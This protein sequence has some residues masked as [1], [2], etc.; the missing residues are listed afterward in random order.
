MAQA[1]NWLQIG[2]DIDGENAEDYFGGSISMSWDGLIVAIGSNTNNGN[3]VNAGHVRVYENTVGTWTQVGGDIDGE[4]AGD[5]S[6]FTVSL[7]S[8]GS[9]LAI[10]APYNDGNGTDAGHVRI[11]QNV[12]G[13]WLQVGNDIDGENSGDLF[14]HSIE[15]SSDGSIVAI[16]APCNSAIGSHS[17]HVRIFQNMSGNWIQIGNDIDGEA[18]WDNSGF[19]VS[20]NSDGKIVAIG[21]PWNDGNG[22]DAG[23]VRVYQNMAGNWTQIGSNIIGVNAGDRCGQSISLNS[24]GSVLA[25][26]SPYNDGN[27]VDA[28]HVRIFQ[29]ISGTWTQIG[30]DIVGKNAGDLLGGTGALSLNSDGSIVAIGASLNSDN[31]THSGHL[32]VFENIMGTWIQTGS[33]ID[34]EAEGDQSGRTCLSADGTVIAD[35]APFNDG[36][37][38]QSGHVRIF[39][40]NALNISDIYNSKINTDVYPNPSQ[41][42]FSVS[43]SISYNSR[44]DVKLFDISGKLVETY[45]SYDYFSESGPMEFEISK[46]LQTG[47]YML[48]LVTEKEICVKR[49]VISM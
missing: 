11:F 26:G 18:A 35:G 28:G 6:G 10:G 32:R 20:L 8:D 1:Q 19:T 24:N 2:Y 3:G 45:K 40:Y 37:G 38:S 46:K 41:G 22:I 48:Y 29:N 13:A 4:A 27:G 33:D 36:N 25:I 44:I 12:S 17:G 16:G 14:G 5:Q 43:F 42:S 21:A 47:Y 7:S 15:L 49:I 30:D 39:E 31:G 9:I 34:G 23:Q